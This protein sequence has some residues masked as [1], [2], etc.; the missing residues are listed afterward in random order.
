M[1]CP[2]WIP[3]FICPVARLRFHASGGCD[4]FWGIFKGL[5][6][7][8]LSSHFTVYTLM[9]SLLCAKESLSS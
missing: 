8:S 6:G 9:T 4:A 2:H 5:S 7:I 3:W 1:I